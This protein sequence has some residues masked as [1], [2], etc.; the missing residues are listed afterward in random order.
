MQGLERMRLHVVVEEQP[1]IIPDDD[2]HSLSGD[3]HHEEQYIDTAML[4]TA[5]EAL[6][7]SQPME[8]A[9]QPSSVAWQDVSMA[10]SIRAI[11]AL[12]ELHLHRYNQEGLGTRLHGELEQMLEILASPGIQR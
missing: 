2:S 4:D 8:H 3:S 6:L 11:H 10:I 1:L 12:S 9:I 7:R 5:K